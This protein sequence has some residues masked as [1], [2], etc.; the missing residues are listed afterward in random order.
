MFVDYSFTLFRFLTT[1][2]KHIMLIQYWFY[3]G[4]LSV[5]LCDIFRCIWKYLEM[6]QWVH[7]GVIM[8]SGE[9]GISRIFQGM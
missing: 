9:G 7:L 1:M 6:L 8:G 2:S 5:I 4:V 3:L